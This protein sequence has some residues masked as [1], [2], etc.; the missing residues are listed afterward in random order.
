MARP[1]IVTHSK[2]YAPRC[3]TCGSP[4]S[5]QATVEA[6][7]EPRGWHF[8][9]RQGERWI[10]CRTETGGHEFVHFVT[11]VDGRFSHRIAWF[12]PPAPEPPQQMEMEL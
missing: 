5:L 3:P 12:R 6:F 7:G 4:V 9:G 10:K 11:L 2:H 1:E 8:Y